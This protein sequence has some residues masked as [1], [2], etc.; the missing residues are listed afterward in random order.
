MAATATHATI[1]EMLVAVLNLVAKTMNEWPVE[2]PSN[3]G[4]QIRE[5]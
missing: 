1:E 4:K 3:G 2:R 5:L